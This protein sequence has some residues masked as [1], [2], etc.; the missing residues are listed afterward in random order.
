[1]Q[2]NKILLENYGLYKGRKEFELA[3]N[4][5]KSKTPIILF[6]GRNG[7]GKT[8]FLHAIR[9][10]LYGRKSVSDRISQAQYDEF[11]LSKIHRNPL[12]DL[13]ARVARVGIEFDFVT[14][15]V[16][17]NYYVER[18]W[19][20]VQ[21]KVH[22]QVLI[23]KD[24]KSLDDVDS[25]FWESFISDI[26]P[27][28]LSQLFFF[29]GEKIQDIADDIKGNAA[30]A[31]AIQTLLGL[32]LVEKLKSD[33]D[34]YI[35]REA[36][37]VSK[38]DDKKIL[39][40]LEK[41]IAAKRIEI[42]SN[43]AKKATLKSNI[44]GIRSEVKRLEEK[45][46]ATG[47]EFANAREANKAREVRVESLIQECERQ[48]Y[49]QCQE[50]FPLSL[51]PNIAKELSSQL[52]GE[53]LLKKQ[54]IIA[55]E[56]SNLEKELKKLLK[57]EPTSEL[58]KTIQNRIKERTIVK[59][60]FKEV[61]NL[62]ESDTHA[63]KEELNLAQSF[64]A[65][66]VLE[67]TEEIE[68]LTEEL[69][70]IK[71]SINQ[72]PDDQLLQDTYQ[73]LGQYNVKL[74]QG[75]TDLAKFEELSKKLEQ[76]LDK[77][78]RESKKVVERQNEV[79]GFEERSNQ[80]K[81]LNQALDEYLVRLTNLK[82]EHLRKEVVD[83]FNTI[84]RKGEFISN[85]TIDDKTFE[86]T[87]YD[88]KKNP[89]PKEDLSSGEKQIFAIAFLWALA[90]T[91]GRPLPVIVDTPLG[92][93]DSEHRLNLIQN[94]FPKASHQVVLLSTDTEVDESL[95]SELAPHIS[96]CYH[97]K[98]NKKKY[99]TQTEEEYFWKNISETAHV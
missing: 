26:I 63:I 57:N 52:E 67:T 95:F 41:A 28:R 60:D 83:C 97:L 18:A 51:C 23:L 47:A 45:L 99:E 66:K 62:S 37:K 49:Q 81:I 39:L 19:E 70:T 14:Q 72:A 93:L 27:E 1:M 8:T 89:I 20:N 87:V 25:E 22:E 69:R 43:E 24:G 46:R 13:P 50:L 44:D 32:D 73:Q 79:E 29:D 78:N 17:Y 15:G 38:G 16:K 56:F 59:S 40:E 55:G 3:P 54:K 84:A 91:S 80:I 61:H 11:L 31:D 58:L 35:T 96:H 90:K 6:G 34:I 48:I 4:Q 68:R 7:A 42:A 85:V 74:G 86:V 36:K 9:L 92:R 5:G 77:L 94:Y 71:N 2:I 10:A 64:A 53:I 33:L 88:K 98:Y 30:I 75:M 76:D 12:D 82:V 21:G 65:N